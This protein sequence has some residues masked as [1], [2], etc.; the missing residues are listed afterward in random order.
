MTCPKG[1]ANCDFSPS[2]VSPMASSLD[3]SRLSPHACI[4]FLRNVYHHYR[5]WAK[6]VI[7]ILKHSLI[8]SFVRA[9]RHYRRLTK[10]MTGTMLQ[11]PQRCC[12]LCV[13]VCVH[14]MLFAGSLPFS[15]VASHNP[16]F[17]K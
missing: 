15:V 13:H 16:R 4:R 11:Y 17:Q 8:F 2:V 7:I 14:H 9:C 3:L 10:W 6:W 5:R 1:E 12:P